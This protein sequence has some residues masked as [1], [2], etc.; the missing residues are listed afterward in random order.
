MAKKSKVKYA[1]MV[2][3]EC[4][5]RGYITTRNPQ[6]QSDALVMKKYCKVDR[7]H[8]EHKETKKNLGRNEA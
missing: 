3:Q 5:T 8:T 1:G 7:K 2:C 6:N 4:N